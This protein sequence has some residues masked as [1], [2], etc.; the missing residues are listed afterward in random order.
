MIF[1]ANQHIVT[2]GENLR[3][4]AV[5][6]KCQKPFTSAPVTREQITR[7][8]AGEHVQ[9][10]LPTWSPGDRELFVLT[11]TCDACWHKMFSDQGV[12]E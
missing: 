11:G 2:D 12:D 9:D 4:Q 3:I 7:L 1:Y 5:C 10:V 8:M 6:R